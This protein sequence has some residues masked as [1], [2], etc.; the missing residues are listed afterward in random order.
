VCYKRIAFCFD[1]MT[2]VTLRSSLNPYPSLPRPFSSSPPLPQ[3]LLT[4][5]L[6]ALTTTS[7]IPAHHHFPNSCSQPDFKP[8]PPLPQF[9]L[10]TTSPI[11]AHSLTSSPHSSSPSLLT[12]T[13][14]HHSSSPSLPHH[15]L[16]HHHFLLTAWLQAKDF[17]RK[18]EGG[19]RGRG[20]GMTQNCLFT[21]GVCCQLD[22]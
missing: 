13:P 9:L 1:I 20:K 6:Q 14:H 15:S 2:C 17:G 16:P 22:K 21:C 4:A 7:P 12:I 19:R 10:T 11:P 5:W 18:E 8:S 3:F